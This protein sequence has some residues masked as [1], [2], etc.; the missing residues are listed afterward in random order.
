[1][2]KHDLIDQLEKR[3]ASLALSDNAFSARLG[4]SRPQWGFL[5]GGG[6]PGRKTLEAV[7]AA[8]PDMAPQVLSFLLAAKDEKMTESMP[9]NDGTLTEAAR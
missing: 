1:M 7:M 2:P 3:Q 4:L 6:T 5:K 9:D 8:F